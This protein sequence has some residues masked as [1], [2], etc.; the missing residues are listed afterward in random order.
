[1]S[2]RQAVEAVFRDAGVV[3]CLHAVDIDRGREFG[4]GADEPVVLASVFK[5]PLLVAFHREVAAGVLDPR[6][7]VTLLPDE[8]YAGPT[9]ISI[10]ADPVTMS[11]RDLAAMMMTVSDNAAAD[12]VF[13]HVGADAVART[14]QELELRGTRVVGDSRTV[15]DSL[16][17]DSGAAGAAELWERLGTPGVLSRVRA[18]DPLRT[19]ATTCRDMTRL[20]AAIWRD[21]A[22][23]PEECAQMRRL[24][25]LQVWPHRLASGFP[26]DDVMVSGKT[27]T[28][29]TIR[30]EAGVVEYPDGGR[31]AVAVFT[32]SHALA[33]VAPRAD[34]AIGTAARLAV[35]YLRAAG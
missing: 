21:E 29:P 25:G 11:L 4:V 19:S 34:A 3:G 35:Q 16:L 7:P 10:L 32:R 9:G 24:M 26:Y 14:L 6:S 22:A 28:L 5:L 27:G 20:A 12:E 17:D 2:P 13:A 31:Y 8:R 23:P 30:N 33:A 18:L 1:M 15:H